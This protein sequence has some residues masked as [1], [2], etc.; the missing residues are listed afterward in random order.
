[1]HLVKTHQLLPATHFR[2]RPGRSTTDSLHL[3][4]DYIKAAWRR[5]QVVAVLFLDI[6]G[7]FPNAVTDH[8]L[9]NLRVRQILETYVLLVKNMLTGHRNQLRFDDYLSGWFDLDN[10]I[11]QGDPL[12]MLLYLFYNADMLDIVQGRQ[13][14]CLGYVDD[15]ALVAAAGMF[16]KA[17]WMLG[18]MMAKS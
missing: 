15:M 18:K 8:L 16:K 1:M 9:H 7:A 2:G 11:V 4:V 17:H 5:K 3:L 14:R 12:S 13:E 6:E 10:G